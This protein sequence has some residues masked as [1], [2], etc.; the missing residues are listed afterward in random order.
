MPVAKKGTAAKA[1][2]TKAKAKKAAPSRPAGFVP[3]LARESGPGDLDHMAINL[4]A[5][6][7]GGKTYL[8]LSISNQWPKD[9][10]AKRKSITYID[11]VIHVG[12][13][14][15][16]LAGLNQHKIR[17]RYHFNIPQIMGEKNWN[18]LDTINGV[19]DDI[20]EIVEHG[21]IKAVV[22]DTMSSLDW[23][24]CG[25]WFETLE[26][27]N[28]IAIYGKIA[29]THQSYRLGILTLP[30]MPI[31]CFH[32][33][34]VGPD[35]ARKT[36]DKAKQRANRYTIQGEDGAELVPDIT[37]KAARHYFGAASVELVCRSYKSPTTKKWAYDVHPEGFG[38]ARGKNRFRDVLSTKEPADLKAIIAKVRRASK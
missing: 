4:L 9:I 28:T 16:A 19:L 12:W 25:H 22:D 32:L 14:R 11:D 35:L 27:D 34:P 30:V 36:E 2:K 13:D 7:G 6:P 10:Q 21:N 26:T 8:S 15:S 5:I 23:M 17:V 38:Q 3:N 33:R 24:I 37:G 31:S 20:Y 18:I 1:A 29:S